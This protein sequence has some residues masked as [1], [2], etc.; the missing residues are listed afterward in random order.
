MY[1]QI[2]SNK[3]RTVAVII[4]FL[5]TWLAIGVVAGLLFKALYRPA[6][7]NNGYATAPAANYGWSPVI[8]GAAVCAAWR[9]P[10]P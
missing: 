2:A 1:S 7:Y 3:R 8:I 6:A 9:S 5:V 10:T 4:S